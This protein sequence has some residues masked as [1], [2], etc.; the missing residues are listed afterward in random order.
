MSHWTPEELL[1]KR[2]SYWIDRVVVR[3]GC[4]R[5]GPT[6]SGQIQSLSEATKRDFDWGLDLANA[7]GGTLDNGMFIPGVL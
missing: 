5:E 6:R 2:P 7:F 1:S 3:R 4:E